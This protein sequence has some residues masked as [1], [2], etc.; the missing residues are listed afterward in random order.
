MLSNSHSRA[1]ADAD[2]DACALGTCQIP[3]NRWEISPHLLTRESSEKEIQGWVFKV[4]GNAMQVRAKADV[5]WRGT[6]IPFFLTSRTVWLMS[7]ILVA[8][9][10]SSMFNFLLLRSPTYILIKYTFASCMVTQMLLL[11]IDIRARS[12]EACKS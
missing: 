3:R 8:I 1:D 4:K 5:A 9:P 2:A 11:F 6:S 7:T 12:K 10:R